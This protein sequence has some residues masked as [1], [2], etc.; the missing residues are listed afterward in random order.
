VCVITIELICYKIT[1]LVALT[2]IGRSLFSDAFRQ[3]YGLREDMASLPPM[4]DSGSY[5]SALHS[6]IM[7]T[8]S[9]LEFIMFSRYALLRE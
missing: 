5:W 7:P 4:P 2:S 6:W 1:E 9:F 8:P 3:M